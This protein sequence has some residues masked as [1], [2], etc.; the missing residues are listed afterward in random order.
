MDEHLFI[1]LYIPHVS[2][3]P[4]SSANLRDSDTPPVAEDIK[5]NTFVIG[6]LCARHLVIATVP[7]FWKRKQIS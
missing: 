6:A 7:S 2:L 1:L 3:T 5:R 4:T